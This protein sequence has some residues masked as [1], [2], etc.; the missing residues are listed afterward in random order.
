MATPSPSGGS[1]G[2]SGNSPGPA[3]HSQ[4][5]AQHISVS[6]MQEPNTCWRCQNETGL[7]INFTGNA[8]SKRKALKLNFAN[9]PIKP[10]TSFTLNAGV[11]FQNP[12]IERLRTHSIESSGKLKISPE[13]HWDFTAEDLRDLGE[14]GRGAYG[15]VNKMVH[16]PSGQIMAVKRIRSTVDE[17]EQKQLLMDLDV[18]MRSSDCP[19]IVQFYGALFREGDCWICMELMSTSFDKFY[20]Y[21]YGVL[22]DVIPEEILG[23]ITL[24]TVKALNHLKENLKIIHR[25][26]K[27]SNILLDRNGNIKLCDF[28][29]S[30]QLVD[31]IAKT[32][33]AGCRPYMA[34]ERIDPSA[35]RQGYDV[36]S[37]VWSLGITLYEL[38]TGRFPYPK[39]NSVFD[40]LT[41]VVKG[42]P[43]Q[44][45]N[46]EERQF[47]PMFINFVNLCLTKDESKRPKYRELLKHTFILMYEERH[48]DVA[49]Y[50]CKILDHMPASPSSPMYVD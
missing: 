30:G 3:A 1:T 34:P 13:Q 17:K 38:A 14:I 35:S 28:G 42:D 11:S 21:V 46:S 4:P 6:S 50:V 33:D 20:K 18:V 24:A 2:S 8:Q 41:Q 25:D 47:S 23:K 22:D 40:Q 12:H 5:A 9:P 29:I 32:R 10:V 37:D 43:P 49:S 45:S 39:W 26:I 27:P 7:Q 48:V 15:S 44:L 36:R 19:Y 16:K 31:S